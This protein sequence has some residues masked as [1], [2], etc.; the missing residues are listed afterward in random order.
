MFIFKKNIMIYLNV[1][2]TILCLILFAFLMLAIRL[3]YGNKNKMGMFGQF[4]PMMGNGG[5][6]FNLNDFK[7]SMA[8]LSELMK[9]KGKR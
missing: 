1:I 4:P 8:T 6:P 9:N 5:N 2:L 7:N 3:I